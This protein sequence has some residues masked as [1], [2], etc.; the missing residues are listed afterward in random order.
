VAGERTEKPTPRRRQKAR[1]EGHV[2]RSAELVASVI[3]LGVLAGLPG[4][5]P[6]IGQQL[7]EFLLG[8]IAAVGEGAIAPDG[9]GDLARRSLT[10]VG[11]V[12]WPVLG[13]IVAGAL[14]S[15]LAQVGWHFA[16]GQLQPK[17]SRVDP[18]QGIKRL[19]N[20]R[21]AVELLKGI[22]KVLIVASTGWSYCSK[23]WEDLY[24]LSAV[25]PQQVAG[26]VGELAY[27]MARQMAVALA[28]LAALDY[29]YQKW[30]LERSL[31]MT[32]QE[33]SD[34]MRETEGNPE[35]K[36]RIRQRQRETAR[37]RMMTAVPKASVVITNPTHFAVALQYE[38]GQPAPTVVA[39]G[40]DLIAQRIREIAAEH[41]VPRVENPPLART[42]YR[43][44]EVGEQ[45]PP[46]LYRAVAEV[47]ALVWRVDS[48]RT[49]RQAAG[50]GR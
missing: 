45:I 10:E 16:P 49:G 39:K 28:V 9:L 27:G 48:R 8:M 36:A 26:R 19:T 43:S 11:I 21:S 3:L 23:R 13:L 41:G 25:A 20:A 5:V 22:V 6:R 31:K 32:K 15:N 14:A 38:M 42:L 46:E 34:E 50:L 18:F 24:R 47:L 33:V 4:M 40:Q 12:A 44:V 37:R 35:I 29:A 7:S 2:A 17:L 30:Q 1:A